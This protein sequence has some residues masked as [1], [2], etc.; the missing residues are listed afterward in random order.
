MCLL[1]MRQKHSYSSQYVL[2]TDGPKN[3][4]TLDVEGAGFVILDCK[5]PKKVLYKYISYLDGRL[6]YNMA[7]GTKKEAGLNV[8]ANTDP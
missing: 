3:S 5:D 1:L 6:S 2:R 8:H 4:V 7:S